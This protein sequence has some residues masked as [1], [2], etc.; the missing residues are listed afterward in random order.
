MNGEEKHVV[1]TIQGLGD[2]FIKSCDF[3]MNEN[4]NN[5]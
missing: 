2:S 1:V 3:E 5:M 4:Y